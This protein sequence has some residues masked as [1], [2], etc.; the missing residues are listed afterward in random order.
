MPVSFVH[1]GG[2]GGGVRLLTANGD[3]D[4]EGEKSAEAAKCG[5]HRDEREG[6][7]DEEN[8]LHKR[9][10]HARM[11]TRLGDR[12]QVDRRQTTKLYRIRLNPRHS[13]RRLRQK[14]M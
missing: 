2:R 7:N 8:I 1:E 5:E 6:E 3:V 13:V 10:E 11:R 9:G 14:Q 4:V 12:A